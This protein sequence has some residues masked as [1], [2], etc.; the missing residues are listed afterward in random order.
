MAILSKDGKWKVNGTTIPTPSKDIT[1]SHTNVATS[2]SG[3]T[4]DG[5]MHITWVRTDV[6]TISLKYSVLTGV[7]A[8]NL[9]DLLQG[10]TFTFTYYDNG[11]KTMNAYCGETNYTEHS[12]DLHKSEGGIYKDFSANIIEL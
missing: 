9:R 3:R 6:T 11:V 8:Q 2:D 7:E 5:K 12:Y 10:K 1:I 4:Q